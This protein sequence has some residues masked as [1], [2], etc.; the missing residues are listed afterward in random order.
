MVF[1]VHVPPVTYAFAPRS[2]PALKQESG[3]NNLV[4][5]EKATAIKNA[6]HQYQITASGSIT[7]KQLNFTGKQNPTEI[8]SNFGNPHSNFLKKPNLVC[9]LVCGLGP[10]TPQHATPQNHG[11]GCYTLVFAPRHALGRNSN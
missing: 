3:T 6:Q 9:L 5:N 2:A 7:S 8:S 11:C 10:C 4:S 1:R